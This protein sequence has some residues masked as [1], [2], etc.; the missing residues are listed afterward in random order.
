LSSSASWARAATGLAA[1]LLTCGSAATIVSGVL[2]TAITPQP[3]GATPAAPVE[4]VD[5]QTATAAEV[6]ADLTRLDSA[7]DA[8]R[9]ATANADAALIHAEADLD[10]ANA[11]AARQRRGAEALERA[12]ARQVDP[13]TTDV[14]EMLG[15]PHAASPTEQSQADDT[16]A[17]RADAQAVAVADARAAVDEATD[18][19]AD[20]ERDQAAAEAGLAELVTA[21]SAR[22][23]ARRA[24]ADQVAW[25]DPAFADRRRADEAAIAGPLLTAIAHQ[26]TRAAEDAAAGS[27]TDGAA[28]APPAAAPTA[29]APAPAAA[30][31][32]PPA[33]APL[34]DPTESASGALEGAW[35][36]D[37]TRVVVDAS[38]GLSL[39][40]L[41]NDAA[42]AGVGLCGSGFR[43]HAE[44]VELR[45]AHC[46]TSEYSVFVAPPSTCSPPTARP[47]TSNHEDGPGHRL[48]VRRRAAHDPRQPVL[49]VAG[50][51]RDQLRAS[52]PA[53][54]A[55]ALVGHRHLS[56]S[57]QP[58]ELMRRRIAASF[59][60]N[61]G[62]LMDH[63]CGSSSRSTAAS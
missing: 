4:H 46:G 1:A 39:Q 2:G 14:F 8:A 20:A 42:A 61:A 30:P 25:I 27:G 5:P 51:Q 10:A 16:S 29:P 21:A 18:A 58:R 33:P 23:E 49:P 7:V 12:Q 63:T 47:G 13:P 60:W 43:S 31:A 9:T 45:R 35:C 28:A 62:W 55:L 52:Q 26:Q 6:V 57:G 3:A 22:G 59:S 48:L 53:Q 32:P 56:R 41:I 44:Q 54:R 15:R 11:R 40:F 24:E 36:A 17:D 38:L 19:S 34:P 50:G 37:G